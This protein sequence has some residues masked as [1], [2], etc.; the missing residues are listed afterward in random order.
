MRFAGLDP[1][2]IAAALA[3]VAAATIVIALLR[4]IVAISYVSIVYLVPV[5]I[6]A[7][8]LG[9]VPALAAAVAGVAASM[10]FFYPPIYSFR[11][12]DPQHILDLVLFVMVAVVISRLA[13]SYL[14][15]VA[16]ARMRQETDLLR[17]ALIGS[18][19][20]E[21]RTPLASILGAATVLVE[22]PT[23]AGDA[24]LKMLAG[25]IRDE[26][27]R[28]DGDIQNLLDSSR[29]ARD[30]VR[31]HRQWCD[32]ADI[33]NAAI[34]RR[35]RRLAGHDVRLDVARDLPLVDVDA[36]LIEQALGH[37]LDNAGKYSAAG[38]VIRVAARRLPDEVA[39]SVADQGPGL[40]EEERARAGERF[41][42]GPRH[43]TTLPGSG[44][45]LWI[46]RA[47][48]TANGGSLDAQS[49]G[50]GQGA[51]FSIRLPAAGSASGP[52]A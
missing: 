15:V 48:V 19:S 50:P 13:T 40:T 46:A 37:L 3:M 12:A 47:F 27:E 45:G 10:Y 49:P 39:F 1:L 31:P 4:Q 5:F 2:R 29:V 23:V 17:E 32:P 35:R 43:A 36:L 9:L 6:A 33:V 44:L 11:I 18:V 20:H 52:P 16:E 7:M 25:I 8:R 22:T 21:L 41:F 42:R 34:E 14:S 30:G 51:T 24:R 28:L 38:T 26:A